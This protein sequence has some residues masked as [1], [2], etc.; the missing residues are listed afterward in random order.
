MIDTYYIVKQYNTEK[1]LTLDRTKGYQWG[2]SFDEA[3]TFSDIEKEITLE[4]LDG[5]FRGS[6][7]FDG[8]YFELIQIGYIPKDNYLNSDNDDLPF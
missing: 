3:T 5:I 6:D 1:Y 2:D 8:V 7:I 4:K